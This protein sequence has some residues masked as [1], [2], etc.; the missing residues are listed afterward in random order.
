MRTYWCIE[1]IK[2]FQKKKTT[3]TTILRTHSRIVANDLLQRVPQL[4]QSFSGRGR[5]IAASELQNPQPP[6]RQQRE[7]RWVPRRRRQDRNDLEGGEEAQNPA[8][9]LEGAVV[10]EVGDIGPE[11][12]D[13]SA[14]EEALELA[15]RL[16]PRLHVV[17][18][19]WVELQH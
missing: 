13:G 18:A 7:R 3:T 15:Q 14:G 1:E 2:Y 19:H 10:A 11:V 12:I 9:L 6:K 8:E 4:E 5:Q 17:E 16:E